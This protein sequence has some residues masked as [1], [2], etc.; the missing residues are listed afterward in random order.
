MG[1]TITVDDVIKTKRY[2]EKVQGRLDKSK[3]IS[4]KPKPEIE[5]EK[6]TVISSKTIA[7]K[8]QEKI[9]QQKEDMAEKKMKKELAEKKM[10]KEQDDKNSKPIIKKQFGVDNGKV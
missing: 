8:R 6:K 1:K 4:E 10:K 7:E 3:I 9:E 2:Q 5:P